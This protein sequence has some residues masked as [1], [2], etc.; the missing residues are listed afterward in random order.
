MPCPNSTTLKVSALIFKYAVFIIPGVTVPRCLRHRN[1]YHRA[2]DDE[3][4]GS[5]T[6]DDSMGRVLAV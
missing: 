4:H 2:S 3:S 5:G 1:I 6:E